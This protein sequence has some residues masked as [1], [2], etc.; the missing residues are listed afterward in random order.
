MEIYESALVWIPKNSLMRK[1]YIID[2]SKVP[3]VVLGLSE[4]WGPAELIMQNGSMVESVAFSQDS[5]QVASGSHDK[6]V[7]I[8]NVMMGEV[9]A[10][11]KGHT[12]W[13]RSVAFSQDGSRVVSGSDDQT[14][15]IWNV[16]TGEVEAKLKG[17]TKSVKSVAFSQDG[18]R[19]V[20]GSD[21]KMVRIWNVMTGE[22]E[23]ELKGDDENSNSGII[24]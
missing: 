14:V 1:T 19:V 3:K 7:R 10:E 4:S 8:W 22:V 16:A 24:L 2:V 20:S 17:H 23:A 12:N 21:D 6:T 9:E 11:L 15:R 18:S 13:V 5:S